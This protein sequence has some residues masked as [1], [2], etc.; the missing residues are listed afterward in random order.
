MK[1][2]IILILSS[3][4]IITN[5]LAAKVE[6]G[7][8]ECISNKFEEISN[9]TLQGMEIIAN[10]K[11]TINISVIKARPHSATQDDY[12]LK[13]RSDYAYNSNFK[14]GNN[15][16]L[17]IDGETIKFKYDYLTKGKFVSF[18]SSLSKNFYLTDEMIQKIK[19]GKYI[20]LEVEN[21]YSGKNVPNS[22]KG[23]LKPSQIAKVKTLIN[24]KAP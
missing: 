4:L 17:T 5:A 20:T 14:P 21:R 3:L 12:F 2:V 6:T 15:L 22:I 19:N 8:I 16:W 13:I 1:K 7:E 9:C 18:K 11:H 24:T 23:T 10:D